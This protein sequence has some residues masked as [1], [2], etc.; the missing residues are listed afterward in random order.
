MKR[1]FMLLV[2]VLMMTVAGCSSSGGGS[3]DSGDGHGGDGSLDYISANIGT[4]KYVPA[5]AFLR[6]GNNSNLNIST[7]TTAFRMSQYEITQAQYVAV[8]AAANPSNFNGATLPVEQVTWF[9][10]VEFCNDLSALEGFTPVYTITDRVPLITAVPNHPITSAT[11]SPVW[12]NTGYRLPTEMEWMWAAMGATSGSGW[13]SPTYLTGYGKPFAGSNATNA[14]GDNGTNVFSDYAWTWENSSDGTK[15][16]GTTGGA[17]G[18]SNELGLYDMSG[19]VLEWVWDWL[20]GY[21]DGPLASNTDA[22]RGAA[23]GTSRVLRGGSWYYDA[24]LSAVAPRTYNAPDFQ[25]DI[26][27]FRVV[28][29]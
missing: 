11:I 18:H 23:S 17:Q 15:P 9:D 12:G 20:A 24:Y 6:D 26:I 4:L 3:G 14:A 16:V 13:S 29:P 1:L 10:A 19:N 2:A 28:R 5:G 25:D 22:G 8:T 27:G 7:V 21:P